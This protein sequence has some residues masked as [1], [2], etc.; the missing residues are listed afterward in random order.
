[1]ATRRTGAVISGARLARPN[2][3]LHN[4]RAT[5]RHTDCLVSVPATTAALVRARRCLALNDA[6]PDVRSRWVR[7]S[8]TTLDSR[9]SQRRRYYDHLRAPAGVDVGGQFNSDH[10]RWLT[11]RLDPGFA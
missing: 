2:R 6:V 4:G 8:V 1:M 7:A 11:P 9:A 3:N 5:A 10:D